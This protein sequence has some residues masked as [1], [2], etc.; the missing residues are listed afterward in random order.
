MGDEERGRKTLY[1]VGAHSILWTCHSTE[2]TRGRYFQLFMLSPRMFNTGITAHGRMVRRVVGFVYSCILRRYMCRNSSA[3][4]PSVFYAQYLISSLL[5]VAYL[6][7]ITV[8]TDW[9]VHSM[10]QDRSRGCGSCTRASTCTCSVTRWIE[11]RS[12]GFT[13]LGDG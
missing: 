8:Y 3:D 7:S 10:I 4:Q 13:K 5:V 11:A 6:M 1:V 9:L 2:D 12:I